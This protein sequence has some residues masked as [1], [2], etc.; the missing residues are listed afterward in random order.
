[1]TIMFTGALWP[2]NGQPVVLRWISKIIIPAT[3]PSTAA[4]AI[5]AKGLV[6]VCATT[7]YSLSSPPGLGLGDE[8]VFVGFIDVVAWIIVIYFLAIVFFRTE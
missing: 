1:M 3:W 8:P 4:S 6:C 2:L 7:F 5:G